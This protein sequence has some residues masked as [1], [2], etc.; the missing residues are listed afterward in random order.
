MTKSIVILM[1]SLSLMA[2]GGG[3]SQE[4]KAA[5]TATAPSSTDTNKT[6]GLSAV[7]VDELFN[8]S[9]KYSLNLDVDLGLGDVRAYLNIC[10]KKES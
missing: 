8:L 1:L 3:D 10:Q 7:K 9:T 2:C 6:S 4:T 5:P